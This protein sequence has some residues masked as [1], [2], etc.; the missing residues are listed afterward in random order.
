MNYHT[1]NYFFNCADLHFR[2][3]IVPDKQ[4]LDH[5][6]FNQTHEDWYYK[7][8]RRIREPYVQCC[9]RAAVSHRLLLDFI[10]P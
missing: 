3:L 7:R 9:E 10:I 8:K 1:L 6:R 4:Q 2:C 5:V